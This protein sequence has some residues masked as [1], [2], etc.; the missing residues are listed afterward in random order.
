MAEIVVD[1]TTEEQVEPREA[2]S[3]DSVVPAGTLLTERVA[4]LF[5]LKPSEVSRY[6]SKLNTLI[7]YAKIKTDDHSVDGL[8]W[9]IKSL[10]TKLGTPPL[11][12]K[13]LPYL[14]KYAYLYLESRKIEKEM[15]KYHDGE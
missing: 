11:G 4:Q 12:E 14:T 10:G 1:S 7:A 3:P 2:R 15:E 8:K 9:A 13:L 6:T 5:D